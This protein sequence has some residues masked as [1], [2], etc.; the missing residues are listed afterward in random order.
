MSAD[1]SFTP[2][3]AQKTA[4]YHG[5]C[6]IDESNP[7]KGGGLNVF[8]SFEEAC[9]LQVSLQSALIAINRHKRSTKL[10]KSIGVGLWVDPSGATLKVYEQKR[11]SAEK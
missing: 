3:P 8:I 5:S 6:R 7:R 10:G 1:R 4:D 2:Q 11:S 9:K